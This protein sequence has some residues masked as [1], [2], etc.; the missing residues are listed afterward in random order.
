MLSKI[1][2]ISESQRF[3]DLFAMKNYSEEVSGALDLFQAFSSFFQEKVRL[4]LAGVNYDNLLDLNIVNPSLRTPEEIN[5]I[6]NN[7]RKKW[8]NRVYELENSKEYLDA[9]EDEKLAMYRRLIKE[10]MS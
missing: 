1:S 6:M 5:Q 4:T 7:D 3:E 2:S 8:E 9:D 10:M